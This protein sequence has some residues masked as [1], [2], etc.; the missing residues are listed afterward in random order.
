[1]QKPLKSHK[2]KSIAI[3]NADVDIGI[4]PVVKWICSFPGAFTEYSC[5]GNARKSE[6]EFEEEGDR[7]YI[8]FYVTSPMTLISICNWTGGYADIEVEFYERSGGLRYT[9]RF[10]NKQMLDDFI[11]WELLGK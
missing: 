7:P 5:Q 1:M 8:V 4:I 10:R 9:M 2:T 3:K 6:E 11:S